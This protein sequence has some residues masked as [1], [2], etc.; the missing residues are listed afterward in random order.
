MRRVSMDFQGQ[1]VTG[2]SER[3]GD[4]LWVYVNGK[5]FCV[6]SVSRQRKK[7]GPEAQESTGEV[8]APM[9]G[10]IIKIEVKEGAEV[11]LNQTLVVM[12]AMKMEYTLK[13][14]TA[15]RVEKLGC[16]V[17][18]QVALGQLLVLVGGD[19]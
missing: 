9:P 6:E 11:A 3:L 2:F 10:K 7:R 4:K 15:G 8:L 1:R 5:T 17:G 19:E 16:H 12:E 13:S 18:D 14:K